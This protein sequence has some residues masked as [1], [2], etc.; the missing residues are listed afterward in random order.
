MV[1]WAWI[2]VLW[3][4]RQKGQIFGVILGY[5]LSLRYPVPKYRKQTNQKRKK[6]WPLL[7]VSGS[8]GYFHYGNEV[9]VMVQCLLVPPLPNI[10][11]DQKLEIFLLI[12]LEARS[13]VQVQVGA[14]LVSSLLCCLLCFLSWPFFSLWDRVSLFS[15]GMEHVWRLGWS[16]LH[17]DPPASASQVLKFRVYTAT[18]WSHDSSYAHPAFETYFTRYKLPKGKR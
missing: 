7:M 2:P 14:G 4:W 11:V 9:C 18:Q 17:W 6:N 13:K 15:P 12:I 8:H 10:T 1:V 16:W 5:I 3:R